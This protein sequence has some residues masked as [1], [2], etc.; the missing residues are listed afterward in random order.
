MQEY[1][2]NIF[3]SISTKS[4]LKKILKKK[5]ITV[6]KTLATSATFIKSGDRIVL[7]IPKKVVRKKELILALKVLFEDDHLALIHKPPG[8]LV[9]G[10][11]FKTISNALTQNL[12]GSTLTDAITSQPVHRLDFGTTGILLIG[13]TRGSIRALNKCFERK[14]I[15]KTYYAITIGNMS[16]QRTI[17]SDIEGK[18]SIS[19]YQVCASVRSHRFGKLNLIQLE[20]HTGRRHQLRKHLSLIGNPILGDVTYG[21]APLIL[22]GKGLYLHAYSLQF[23]HPFTHKEIHVVDELPR[24]FKKIFSSFEDN[25]SLII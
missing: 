15:K 16:P 17:T 23:I 18:K 19:S 6:N 22:K 7:S 14:E 13:K 21:K 20:P 9:S 5:Y 12:K 24:K 4:A 1:G 8:I 3:N 2:V 10:N 11:S 25:G